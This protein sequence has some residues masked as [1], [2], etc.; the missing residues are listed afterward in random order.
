MLLQKKITHIKLEINMKENI[1]YIVDIVSI[2]ILIEYII[3]Q[4]KNKK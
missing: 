1:I 4:I 3:H 2:I